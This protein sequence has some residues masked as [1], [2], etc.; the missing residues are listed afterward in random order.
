MVVSVGPPGGGK[1]TLAKALA[2]AYGVSVLEVGNLLGAEIRAQTPLGKQIAP[3]KVAGELVPSELV[4][5]VLS[6]ELERVESQWVLFDGFPRAHAQVDILDELLKKHHLRLC[7]ILLLD[8]DAQTALERI[9]GRRVCVNCGAI[10]NI[11]TQPPPQ[12]GICDRCGGKLIQR[13]DDRDETVRQRFKTYER[14]TVPVI[15]YLKKHYA[16]VIWEEPPGP[17]DD[18]VRR[19]WRRFEEATQASPGSTDSGTAHER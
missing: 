1:T 3:Y 12:V 14:E 16:D 17:P 8:L 9:A 2:A 10:Y 13:E 18:L 5:Q 7:G 19:V 4:N 15:D 6:R 11:Y